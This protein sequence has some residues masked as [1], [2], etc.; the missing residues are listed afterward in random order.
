MPARPERDIAGP[1]P[2]DEPRP[3]GQPDD[4][5]AEARASS[6]PRNRMLGEF[7]GPWLADRDRRVVPQPLISG[8]EAGWRGGLRTSMTGISFFQRTRPVPS[9]RT[10]SRKSCS[11]VG[12]GIGNLMGRKPGREDGNRDAGR[13][14]GRDLLR[15]MSRRLKTD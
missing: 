9:S 3:V 5:V 8:A 6:R 14:P 13:K 4:D 7:P 12:G 15:R 11:S 10:T 2:E 1:A